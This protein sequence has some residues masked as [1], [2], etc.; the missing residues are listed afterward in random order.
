MSCM[1]APGAGGSAPEIF[2]IEIDRLN[3]LQAHGL[4]H[5]LDRL[6]KPSLAHM[7]LKTT[8]FV[9]V[10]LRTDGRPFYLTTVAPLDLGVENNPVGN[11][12]GGFFAPFGVADV[13]GTV[14]G[15]LAAPG[16]LPTSFKVTA[17]LLLDA[18]GNPGT[19]DPR[20]KPHVSVEWEVIGNQA[21]RANKSALISSINIIDPGPHDPADIRRCIALHAPAR[22]FGLVRAV[23]AMQCGVAAACLVEAIC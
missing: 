20:R 4:A 12:S 7:D 11:W 5:I 16:A 15:C 22:C 23:V 17:Q 2:P 1:F 6:G 3:D 10:A 18:G 9:G 8:Q 13:V 21:T 14:E 19:P